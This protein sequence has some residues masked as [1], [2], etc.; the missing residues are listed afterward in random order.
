M[1]P[2]STLMYGSSLMLV[3]RMLR[4]SRIAA[5]EAAAMPFPREETTPPVTKT[6]LVIYLARV[7]MEE[8]TRKTRSQRDAKLR[9]GLFAHVFERD[10]RVQFFQH[11]ALAGLD[12]EHAQVGDDHVDHALA[13]D[14]QRAALEDFGGPV[15]RGVLH[16]DDYALHSGYQVHG[17]TRSF[18]H[19]AG[20]H[21]V[22]EVAVL[23]HLQPAKD[24]EVDVAAAH[25]GE[26][27]GAG[28]EARTRDRGHGLL[29]RVDKV[30]VDLILGRA[31]SY[32]EHTVFRLHVNF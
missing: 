23:R 22:G 6:Y 10:A 3:T 1:V 18:H 26:G 20:H 16:Q 25:H 4:D 24:G 30:R 28:E 14:R 32:P 7:G 5:R 17:A 9:S 13:G 2:G 15:F 31:R 12:L 29:A 19:L 21:P 8:S 27:V 11:E